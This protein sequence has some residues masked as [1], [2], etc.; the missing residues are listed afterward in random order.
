V[1]K[2]LKSGLITR[3]SYAYAYA[4]SYSYDYAYANA[5]VSP[6]KLQLSQIKK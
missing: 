5:Y 3:G 6:K 2:S 1:L 4:Y